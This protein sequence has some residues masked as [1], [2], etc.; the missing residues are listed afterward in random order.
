MLPDLQYIPFGSAAFSVAGYTNT[1][2]LNGYLDDYLN[3]YLNDHPNGYLNGV[4][5]KQIASAGTGNR[6]SESVPKVM[7]RQVQ[8]VRSCE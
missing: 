4:F 8:F 2:Y 3:G 1:N 5:M 7:R 6:F